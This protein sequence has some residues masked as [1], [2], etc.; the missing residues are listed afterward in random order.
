MSVA[1]KTDSDT[2]KTRIPHGSEAMSL[3]LVGV[4][5]SHV[6]SITGISEASVNRMKRVLDGIESP[7][8]VDTCAKILRLSYRRVYHL[9]ESGELK[10]Q[11][12][13]GV[14]PS[15]LVEKEQLGR[16]A[17][18]RLAHDGEK[19]SRYLLFSGKNPNTVALR[20][21]KPVAWVS[22]LKQRMQKMGIG[23]ESVGPYTVV[24]AAQVLGLHGRQIRTYCAQGRMGTRW[25]MQYQ[26][27]REELLKFGAL[28]RRS[29]L[30]SLEG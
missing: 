6:A 25:G 19:R 29:G 15:M 16:F 17:D 8:S 11:R 9:I 27:S 21:R 7:F 2:K 23:P 26:I 18:R 24:Q 1:T 3:L 12:A 14:Y 30:G 20:A 4:G 13:D 5:A 22:S 10:L 28:D